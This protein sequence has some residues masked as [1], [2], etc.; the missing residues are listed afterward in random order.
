MPPI[1]PQLVRTTSHMVPQH[2][3]PQTNSD[4]MQTMA[5]YS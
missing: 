4:T 5:T 3:P 2:L 1:S